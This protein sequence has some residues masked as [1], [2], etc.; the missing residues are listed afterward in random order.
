MADLDAADQRPRPFEL[1]LGARAQ[2]DDDADA[3]LVDEARDV[4]LGQPLQVVGPDEHA[5]R[6]DAAALDRQPADVADVDRALE[7]N[8]GGQGRPTRWWR[9]SPRRPG[10]RRPPPPWSTSPGTRRASGL[11]ADDDV[12][13][14]RTGGEPAVADRVQRAVLRHVPLVEVRPVLVLP[15]PDV[16]RGALR[17]RHAERVAA[18]AAL[19]EDV[20]GG[21]LVLG[22]R[23]ALLAAGG[24][25]HRRSRRTDVAISSARRNLVIGCDSIGERCVCGLLPPSPWS[26][27][28]SPSAGC[29]SAGA[30]VR[31]R[32]DSVHRHARRLPDPAP[33]GARARR[34]GD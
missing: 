3:E 28:R 1:E 8:P 32:G 18:G 16:G 17:T 7:V 34:T 22:D 2:V 24:E 5:R 13:R 20:R 23:D 9:G 4:A 27:S 6:G 30:P 11:L 26:R 21:P 15:G 12:L 14:H 31:E 25:H 33:G 29:G 10:R 19:I